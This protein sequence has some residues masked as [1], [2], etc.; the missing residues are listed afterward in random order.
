MRVLAVVMF[1]VFSLLFVFPVYADF[2]ENSSLPHNRHWSLTADVERM[3][4]ITMNGADLS[5]RDFFGFSYKRYFNR[6]VGAGGSVSSAK[7]DGGRTWNNGWN[8][9]RADVS[10]VFL[11]AMVLGRLPVFSF[12]D[13]YAGAG[14]GVVLFSVEQNFEG[15]VLAEYK[16]QEETVYALAPVCEL[17]A[18]FYVK[19]FTAGIL[20]R[21]VYGHVRT[22]TADFAGERISIGG[23]SLGGDFGI[24]F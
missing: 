4:G 15:V 1:F 16:K 7:Y 21:Y 10:E 8:I 3:S 2:Y 23:V 6:H 12:L 18:R 13:I 24:S 19:N 17:G 9:Y 20:A 22:K 14:L 5:D 11:S